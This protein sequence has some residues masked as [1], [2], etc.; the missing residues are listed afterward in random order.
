M[1]DTDTKD[2]EEMQRK[3]KNTNKNKG[4]ENWREGGR[5]NLVALGAAAEASESMSRRDP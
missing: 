2:C 1:R 5:G 4:E 3:F